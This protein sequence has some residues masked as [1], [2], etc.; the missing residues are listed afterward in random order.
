M[1]GSPRQRF[2]LR[3]TIGYVIFAGAWILLSDKVLALLASPE[4]LTRYSTLKGMAFV[5]ATAVMLW[6]TWT[7]ARALGFDRGDAI[8]IQFCGT[9]KSLATGLPMATVLFAGHPIGLMM[10]PLIVFHQAQLMACSALASRYAR[11]PAIAG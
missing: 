8:A 3:V 4:I 10:L 11:D 9:K 7:V 2:G 6:L 1:H 5:L